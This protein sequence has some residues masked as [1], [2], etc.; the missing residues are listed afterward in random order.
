MNLDNLLSLHEETTTRC[1]EIM[2]QKNM[3]YSGGDGDPFANFRIAEA[4]GVHPVMGII[5]RSTDKLQ[6]VRAFIK[7]GVCAVDGESVDDACDDLVNYAILMKGLLRE[8]RG[9]KATPGHE[10]LEASYETITG[11]PPEEKWLNIPNK[12]VPRFIKL[13]R[14]EVIEAGDQIKYIDEGESSWRTVSSYLIGSTFE[15]GL[16]LLAIRRPL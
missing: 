2:R 9:K 12:V 4:Y 7:N 6:R 15:D 10:T 11:H 8:E 14:G 16:E 3:D 1:R 5:L 13:N